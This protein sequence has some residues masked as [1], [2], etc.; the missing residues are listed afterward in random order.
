MSKKISVGFLVLLALLTPLLFSPAK[1]AQAFSLGSA[2]SSIGG[3]LTK[4]P[5]G[6]KVLAWFPCTCNEDG[7]IWMILGMPSPGVYLYK[8][9]ETKLY[10]KSN[11]LKIGGYHLGWRQKLTGDSECSMY[12][13]EDCVDWY[14]QYIIK[15]IGTS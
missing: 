4:E 10:A 3:A 7:A 14:Y 6:A 1:P 5:Y 8:P 12:V 13:Y 15:E 11:P 2:A 9:A